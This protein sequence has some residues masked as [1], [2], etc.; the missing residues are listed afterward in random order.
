MVAVGVLVHGVQRLLDDAVEVDGQ[1]VLQQ[2]PGDLGALQHAARRL[3][4]VVQRRLAPQH[5]REATGHC[6]AQVCSSQ[7][8]QT[9]AAVTTVAAVSALVTSQVR[10]LAGG[11]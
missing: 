3:T 1:P 8:N 2:L 5:L 7:V 6:T 10:L 11:V 4:Q 9:A